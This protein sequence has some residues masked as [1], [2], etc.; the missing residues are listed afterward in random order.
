MDVNEE[1]N[2]CKQNCKSHVYYKCSACG[3][4]HDGTEGAPKTC[5]KCDNDKFY[6]IVK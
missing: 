6:K 2:Q 1:K 3:V 5:M 4:I